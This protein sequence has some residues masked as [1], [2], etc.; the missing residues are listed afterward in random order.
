MVRTY[1]RKPHTCIILEFPNSNL[2]SRTHKES[3]T[4]SIPLNYVTERR[5]VLR[6]P[7]AGAFDFNFAAAFA[8]AFAV[9]FAF[10][11]AVAFAFACAF[12]AVL[13][14]SSIAT[15]LY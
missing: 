3:K 6:L 2:K 13:F 1:D 11:F 7:L 9:A 15:F 12:F 14:S 5:L 4:E 8:S 10:A